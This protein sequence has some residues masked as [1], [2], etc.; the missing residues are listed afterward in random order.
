M[1]FDI[2]V[3]D[4]LSKYKVEKLPSIKNGSFREKEYSHILPRNMWEYNLLPHLRHEMLNYIESNNLKKKFHKYFHHLN[5]SQAMCLNF[6]IPLI[7]DKKLELILPFLGL[8][9]HQIDYST[10]CFEKE[11]LER[12]YNR[13]ATSFDFFFKTTSELC[14]YFEI[15]YTENGFGCA[16]KSSE[17]NY[18]QKYSE[19]YAKLLKPISQEYQNCNSF[20]KYYQLLRNLIH[21]D[22]KSHVVFLSPNENEKIMTQSN[23]AKKKLLLEGYRNNLHLLTWRRLV[24]EVHRELGHSSLK[25]HFVEFSDKYLPLGVSL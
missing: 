21:I 9:G 20:L 14:V 24:E 16:S 6:F 25:E 19:V 11:G 23:F 4:H 13:T 5:S 7:I 10:V 22:E 17:Y 3:K 12:K 2:S 18:D 1:K 8:H 15:K